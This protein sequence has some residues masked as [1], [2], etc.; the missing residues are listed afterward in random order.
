MATLTAKFE[1]RWVAKAAPGAGLFQLGSAF[2][3][4][5]QAFRVFK[6]ALQTLHYWPFLRAICPKETPSPSESTV[7]SRKNGYAPLGAR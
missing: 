1:L 5:A 4:K 3:A 6:M 2:G 7:T